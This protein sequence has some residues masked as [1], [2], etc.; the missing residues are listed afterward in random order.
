MRT[1]DGT[2]LLIYILL[3]EIP[4][5]Y[6]IQAQEL[7][8]MYITFLNIHNLMNPLIFKALKQGKII[9]IG[10]NYAAHAKE[11]SNPVPDKEPIIF[12][13]PQS[14][15]LLEGKPII[16][17]KNVD[18]HHEIEL[19]LVMGN[20]GKNIPVNKANQY[21]MGYLLA[22][23]MTARDIQAKAKKEGHPWTIAKGFDTFCPISRFIRK[24]EIKDPQD[25]EIWLKVNG[26]M[27]QKSNTKHMIF[28]I[29]FLISY[30]STIMTLEEGDVI[31]TGTPEGVG[32][33]VPGDTLVGGITGLLEMKFN[34][35]KDMRD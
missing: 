12:L 27:R 21:V 4:F 17:P 6:L 11:L 18:V 23:D 10:R 33:V 22:L 34:V 16:A 13:K 35:V 30:V 14:S 8:L 9:G 7:I 19:A 5:K 20:G 31:L 2:Q 3:C 24:S 28:N 15:Y 32:P 1:K 29:P 26:T 25:V